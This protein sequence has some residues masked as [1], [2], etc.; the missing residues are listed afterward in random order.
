MS[1]V[2]KGLV[3]LWHNLDDNFILLISQNNMLTEIVDLDKLQ[4][5]K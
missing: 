4:K 2:N 3:A 1:A 5:R